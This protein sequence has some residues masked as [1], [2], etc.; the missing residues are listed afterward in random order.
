MPFLILILANYLLVL[1]LVYEEGPFGLFQKL[2]YLAGINVPEEIYGMDRQIES[3]EYRSNGSL[4]AG[5]LSCHRCTS[6][7]TAALVVL[8]AAVTG[9]MPLQWGLLL[10]W[11]ATAGG[12][13]F[14]FEIMER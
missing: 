14:L 9:F 6:P 2:R 13:V 11:L 3:V 12:A 5:I 4:T 7:Y 8:I 1:Y 10:Y